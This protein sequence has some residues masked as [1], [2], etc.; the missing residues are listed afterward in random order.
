MSVHNFAGMVATIEAAPVAVPEHQ[1]IVL[2]IFSAVAAGDFHG[3]QEYFT[4]DAQLHI[5]GFGPFNGSWSGREDVLAA[6]TTNFGKLA[7]Q[8]PVIEAILDQGNSLAIR[9]NESGHLKPDRR[10][11]HLQGVIWF[12]FEGKQ[13]KQIHEFL[14]DEMAA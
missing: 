10:P 14:H 5:Y 12:T 7:S 4:R 1:G 13:V 8:T 9:I 6:I 2:A 3:L 11:Y